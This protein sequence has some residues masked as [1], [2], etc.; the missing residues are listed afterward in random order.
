M[1]DKSFKNAPF[2]IYNVWAWNKRLWVREQN[3]FL[4]NTLAWNLKKEKKEIAMLS[5]AD[6]RLYLR[7]SCAWVQHRQM[8][9]SKLFHGCQRLICLYWT[10]VRCS[11]GWWKNTNI[12]FSIRVKTIRWCFLL[13]GQ[14]WILAASFILSNCP[15]TRSQLFSASLKN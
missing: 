1:L 15:Q 5:S 13:S 10:T 2:R 7:Q 4:V 11:K 8:K 3:N 6:T 14:F 12:L 9:W